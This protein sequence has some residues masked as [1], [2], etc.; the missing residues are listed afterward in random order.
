MASPGR[1]QGT[2]KTGGR[3]KGTPNKSTAEIKELAQT[4]STDALKTLATIMLTSENDTAKIAAAKELL[5]RGYGKPTQA[6]EHSGPDGGP[7]VVQ[8]IELVGLE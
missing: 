3:V 7:V 4:Y 5:D 8:R 6:M 2:I 1:K